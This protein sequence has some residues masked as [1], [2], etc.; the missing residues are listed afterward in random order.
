MLESWLIL[1]T[2]KRV[3][4]YKSFYWML[5]GILCWRWSP[6]WRSKLSKDI[7]WLNHLEICIFPMYIG[8]C[9]QYTSFLIVNILIDIYF[10]YPLLGEICKQFDVVWNVAFII[11]NY[12]SHSNLNP[13][14]TFQFIYLCLQLSSMTFSVMTSGRSGKIILKTSFNTTLNNLLPIS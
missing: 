10:C 8:L 14:K 3:S 11:C 4:W 12:I 6:L 1:P 9:H 2:H 5:E 13:Q 7:T